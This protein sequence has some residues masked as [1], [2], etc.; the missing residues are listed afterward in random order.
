MHVFPDASQSLFYFLIFPA[1]SPCKSLD[2]A[3]VTVVLLASGLWAANQAHTGL[4][5]SLSSALNTHK[6]EN[7]SFV[8]KLKQEIPLRCF[9]SGLIILGM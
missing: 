6:A 5:A 8:H 4:D 7:I 1:S 3:L 2:G 9:S